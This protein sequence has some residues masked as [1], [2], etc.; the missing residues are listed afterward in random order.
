MK[1]RWITGMVFF[2]VAV[3]GF[4]GHYAPANAKTKMP[5][6]EITIE[7]KKPAKFNHKTHMKLKLTCGA[8]HHNAKHEPL[9]AEA[10][11][12]FPGGE[13]LLCATCHNKD[14]A[15]PKLQKK[16]D[17]FHARCKTCHKT[18]IDGKKG[19]TKC[20]ACHPKKKRKTAIEGC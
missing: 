15:N 3:T 5:K 1:I 11:E 6:K 13:K 17:V 4:I 8:C 2:A 19:P 16:K 12:D 10:I 7:G 20:S 9:S 18:G 14:F